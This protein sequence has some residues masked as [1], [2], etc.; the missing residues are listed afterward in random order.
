M[1]IAHERR[2]SGGA[3]SSP[4]A[5]GRRRG[6]TRGSPPTRRS[7]RARTAPGGRTPISAGS[8]RC[9][10]ISW[11]TA[12]NTAARWWSAATNTRT[13]S[14]TAISTR[15]RPRAPRAARGAG[16]R[17]LA[18]LAEA[19]RPEA[20]LRLRRDGGSAARVRGRD[21]TKPRLVLRP[22]GARRRAPRDRRWDEPSRC[23]TL[24][25]DQKQ[26]ED[27]VT[28]VYRIPMT[29]EWRSPDA[30]AA[31]E[32]RAGFLLEVRERR[33]TIQVPL[34]EAPLRRP[35]SRAPR[36]ETPPLP[37]HGRGAPLR[38]AAFR[39]PDRAHP[40]RARA[41]GAL[42]RARG[43]RP[44]HGAQARRLLGRAR[45]RGRLARGDRPAGPRHR[46]PDRS[47]RPARARASA[48]ARSGRSGGS[49][50]RPP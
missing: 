24:T 12:A 43:D 25:I 30:G 44:L 19:L 7:W 22:V 35:R 14:S 47:G 32:R 3:I 16:G 36:D 5:T 17:C 45:R 38:P 21:R 37:A 9:A 33:Q 20:R 4:A 46:R 41:S 27:E 1:L 31:E 39:I 49:A 29:L 10:P 11:R 2:T 15:G 8:S 50:T 42:G 13:T 34:L 18:P 28:P 23:L 6:F 48:A 26:P 40:L